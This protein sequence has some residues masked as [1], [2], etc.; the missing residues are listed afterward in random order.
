MVEGFG[1]SDLG[2]EQGQSFRIKLKFVHAARPPLFGSRGACL[3]SPIGFGLL[4]TKRQPAVL[5]R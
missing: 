3:G 5:A 4:F 1:Q 2:F